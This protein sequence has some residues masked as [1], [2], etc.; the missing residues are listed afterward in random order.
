[1]MRTAETLYGPYRWERYDLLV[2]PP[3]FPFGGMENP[4][5]TFVTP[6][7]LAGD[8]SLTSLVAHELAHSWSGNLVTNA[9][10]GDMWL[11]E[12][13]TVYIERRIVEEIYGEGRA[14][15]EAVLGLQDLQAELE[16]VGPADERLEVDLLGR[17]PDEAMTDVAYEKGALLL[18]QLERTYGRE[19]FDPFLPRL[20]RRA[21]VHER[22]D[23]GVRDVRPRAAARGRSSL[24]SGPRSPTPRRGSI[25]RACPTGRACPSPT[26]SRRSM[27]RWRR[28]RRGR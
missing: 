11:N 25:G 28:S 22:A 16:R 3:A 2:L 10:W 26:R 5:L 7:I 12:G 6:T 23:F 15:M 27:R 24:G 8:R 21:R 17:D 13:F 18:R 9:T 20:V 14:A 1:M 4:R 19:V